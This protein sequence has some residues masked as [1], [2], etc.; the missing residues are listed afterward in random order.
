[1]CVC[2]HI[3]MCMYVSV[4]V[5]VCTYIQPGCTLHIG[6]IGLFVTPTEL[7]M[8]VIIYRQSEGKTAQ[9]RL[10]NLEGT[11]VGPVMMIGTKKGN[12]DRTIWPKVLEALATRTAARRGVYG[13]A[14]EKWKYA[15]A[16]YVDSYAVHLNRDVALDIAKRFGIFIRPLLRNASHLMQP[17]DRHIGICFKNMY[18]R[19]V[20]IANY[21][22]L[23]MLSMNSENRKMSLKKFIEMCSGAMHTCVNA[24]EYN[25]TLV[26]VW[27]EFVG[28]W[29]EFVGVW[30]ELVGVIVLCCIAQ[31]RRVSEAPPL[32]VDEFWSVQ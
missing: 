14:S 18:K 4:S 20:M 8:A 30:L 23:H 15:L 28:V 22:L 2:V 3:F 26:G 13:S 10:E 19:H 1:M 16:L 27:L 31:P 29:L 24:V 21:T 6:T 7:L 9:E 25:S 32:G 12:M 5:Y 11:D 17:V